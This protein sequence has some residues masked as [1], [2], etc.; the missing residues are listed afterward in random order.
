[1]QNIGEKIL[2]P[3]HFVYMWVASFIT[4]TAFIGAFRVYEKALSNSTSAVD[5]QKFL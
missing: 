4:I 5:T 1:M 3:F 2:L